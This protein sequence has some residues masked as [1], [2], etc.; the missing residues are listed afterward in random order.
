MDE[1]NDEQLAGTKLQDIPVRKLV[2]GLGRLTLGSALFVLTLLSTLTTGAYTLGRAKVDINASPLPPGSRLVQQA[3][4]KVPYVLPTVYSWIRLETSDFTPG[5]SLVADERVFYSLLSYKSPAPDDRFEERY[6]S[7]RTVLEYLPG[8]DAPSGLAFRDASLEWSVPLPMG[9]G[10]YRAI[11]T[12][13]RRQY[14]SDWMSRERRDHDGRLLGP[15]EEDFCYPSSNDSIGEVVISVESATLSFKAP[16]D[17]TRILTV[18]GASNT[19]LQPVVT[20]ALVSGSNVSVATARF[21]TPAPTQESC[22]V[23]SW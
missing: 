12:G 3:N 17:G 4:Q 2:E 8:P 6:T 10:D 16:P 23:V 9:Q 15:R 18:N 11:A 20:R 22:I 13:V 1:P 7:E 14:P 21:A 19:H 5:H